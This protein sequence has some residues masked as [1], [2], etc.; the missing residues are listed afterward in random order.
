MIDLQQHIDA[1]SALWREERSQVGL[2]LGGLIIRLT[3]LPKDMMMQALSHPHSYRGYYSD[4]AFEPTKASD[5]RKVSD[6][7]T[8]CKQIVGKVFE[9]Y[10]GGDFTM[11]HGTPVWIA[12]YGTTGERLMSIT[13]DG[14]LITAPKEN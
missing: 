7:L 13:D 1:M 3:E 8:E 10:K 4:L 11:G 6:Q 2:T 9:G 14:L 5:L 12:S